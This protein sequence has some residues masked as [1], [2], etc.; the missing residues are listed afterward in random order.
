MTQSKSVKLGNV[1]TVTGKNGEKRKTIKLGNEN[2]NKPEYNYTVM[3][4]V[5]N[6]KGETVA[7]LTNPWINLQSPH[8]NAPKT[9]INELSVFLDNETK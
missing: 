4:K 8:P 7:K 9:I 2:S 1:L 3:V 5:L 6:A